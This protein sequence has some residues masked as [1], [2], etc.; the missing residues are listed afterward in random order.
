MAPWNPPTSQEFPAQNW[1]DY[2]D[3]THGVAL[4]NRGL[5]G[6]NV[7]DGTLILSLLRSTEIQAYGD[8][9]LASGTAFEL[10]KEMTVHYAL[11]PHAG[12]WRQARTYRAGLEFNNPF[13]VRATSSHQGSLPGVWGPLDL[14]RQRG[15]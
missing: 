10:G 11:V 15:S 1:A 8:M 14:P 13:I 9:N 7:A 5:P 3:D 2:S 4:V 12:D 6:N